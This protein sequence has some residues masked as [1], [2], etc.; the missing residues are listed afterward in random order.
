VRQGQLSRGRASERWPTDS[1]W[2][3]K[4]HS[5]ASDEAGYDAAI[6]ALAIGGGV[7]IVKASDGKIVGHATRIRNCILAKLPLPSNGMAIDVF[8]GRSFA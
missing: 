3:K 8:N 4:K 1:A 5:P 6:K 7:L 2:K